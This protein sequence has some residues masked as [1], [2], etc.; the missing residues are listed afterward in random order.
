MLILLFKFLLKSLGSVLN[1]LLLFLSNSMLLRL[2][3]LEQEVSPFVQ[4]ICEVI[5][6]IHLNL[7]A[8]LQI[9]IDY[10][11]KLPLKLFLVQL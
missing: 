8:H 5:V 6:S 11:I 7:F 1:F 4:M 10:Q 3:K 9:M 2:F